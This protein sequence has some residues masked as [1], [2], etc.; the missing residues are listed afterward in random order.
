MG[1]GQHFRIA[2]LGG[3]ERV[4]L[5][6]A[7]AAGEGQL[8]F[9]RD[10]LVAEEQDLPLQQRGLQR[11]DRLVRQR[12]GQVDVVHLGPDGRGE[13]R[14]HDGAGADVANDLVHGGASRD[15]GSRHPRGEGRKRPGGRGLASAAGL[16]WLGR[17]M[18]RK[19]RTLAAVA[20]LALGTVVAGCQTNPKQTVLNLDTTDRKWSSPRC[21]AARKAVHRYN[22]GERL[23]AAAGWRTT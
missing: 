20:A 19:T 5:Q 10:R 11:R 17:V 21:V 23:R 7:E 8:L 6:L 3:R 9:G 4:H 1:D 18:D 22:D 12:P 15:D 2:G 14:Q 13:G 16:G